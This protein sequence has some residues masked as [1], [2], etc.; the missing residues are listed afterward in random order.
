M[1]LLPCRCREEQVHSLPN[2]PSYSAIFGPSRFWTWKRTLEIRRFERNNMQLAM[3]KASRQF[4]KEARLAVEYSLRG[5][6]CPDNGRRKAYASRFHP[7]Q[8]F[9][10]LTTSSRTPRLVQKGADLKFQIAY[11]PVLASSVWAPPWMSPSS[12]SVRVKD[13]AYRLLP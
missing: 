6:A 10:A 7:P 13:P 8:I 9:L 1:R 3:A 2:D 12:I 4:E 5:L 11:T